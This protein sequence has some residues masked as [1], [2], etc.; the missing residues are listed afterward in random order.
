MNPYSLLFVC[1]MAISADSSC[2]SLDPTQP[3]SAVPP[4]S[5]FDSWAK[6]IDPF[7]IAQDV[8]YVGTENLSSVL[9]TSPEGHVLIDAALETNAALI[10]TNIESLGFNVTDIKYLLNSH[11]R[12]D[13]AGGLAR[14]KMWSGGQLVASPD[15]AAQLAR[16]GKSDF[17]LG[18]ALPFPPVHVDKIIQ[19]KESFSL[20]AIQVTAL[21]TPGHL[22][23]ATSWKIELSNGQELLYADSLATPG[24]HLI[25]NKNYP[26]LVA[27][28]RY[29]F[30]LLASQSP[31]IFIANKGNRFKLTDKRRRYYSGD[32]EAF[33]DRD[34]LKHY[35]D[36]SRKSFEQQ[37]ANQQNVS[38]DSINK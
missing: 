7:Q 12:L 5:L 30:D 25:N 6:P 34:G 18:D 28:L 38:T 2:A 33:I 17:A 14:L 37:L 1:M 35:V 22:P 15:N 31:D 21:F 9:I 27:D 26:N 32:K 29:S 13:Q 3:L 23:G 16:G 36:A 24:Y 20:G 11:A 10:R 4:M 8:W 19:D